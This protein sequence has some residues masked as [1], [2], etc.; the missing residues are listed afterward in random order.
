MILSTKNYRVEGMTCENCAASVED[1]ISIIAGTQG[2]D[3]DIESGR[4]AVT[5]EGFSDEQIAEAIANAGFKIS[6]S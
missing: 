6:S 1:E 2:V 5:G 3:I 4:V